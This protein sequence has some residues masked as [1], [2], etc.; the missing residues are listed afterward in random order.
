M[1]FDNLVNLDNLSEP[2]DSDFEDPDKIEVPGGGKD[3]ATISNVK[4]SKVNS[5]IN[6]ENNTSSSMAEPKGSSNVSIYPQSMVNFLTQME[7]ALVGGSSS[8]TGPHFN[9]LM[10]QNLQAM[11]IANPS[12]LTG[13]IPNKLLSQMWMSDIMLKGGSKIMAN[14]IPEEDEAYDEELGVAETYSD[15]MPTKCDKLLK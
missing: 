3:L 9:Q 8:E 1:H 2:S 15:Y 5:T 4:T 7:M 11:L 12:Y 6:I 10:L 14:Q 13:G